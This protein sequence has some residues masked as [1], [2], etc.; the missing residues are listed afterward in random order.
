MTECLVLEMQYYNRLVIVPVIYC[1][2]NQPSQESSQFE[3][4]ISQILSDIT[5]KN[6]LFSIIVEDFSAG[7]KCWWGLDTQSKESESELVVI[8]N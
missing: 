6:S 3:M 5:S 7:T 4:L 2:P 1:S 8:N